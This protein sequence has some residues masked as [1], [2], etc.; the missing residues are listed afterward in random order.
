MFLFCSL[1]LLSYRDIRPAITDVNI[2]AATWADI[3]TDTDIDVDA[4]T[5]RIIAMRVPVVVPTR[6]DWLAMLL[7]IGL[8]GFIAQ[9]RLLSRRRPPVAGD[10]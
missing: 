7:M 2:A 4:D 5:D 9:V 1:D 10:R 6:P 8:F 3:G